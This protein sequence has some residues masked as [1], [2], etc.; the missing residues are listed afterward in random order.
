MDKTVLQENEEKRLDSVKRMHIIAAP[1]EAD[2][3]RITRLAKIQFDVPTCV[4]TTVDRHTVW[5]HSNAGSQTTDIP[6]T[7]Q[8]AGTL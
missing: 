6:A 2:F 8:F 7:F 3:D 5:I 4:I 1:R